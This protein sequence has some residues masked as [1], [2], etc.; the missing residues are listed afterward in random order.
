MTVMNAQSF[1]T[2]RVHIARL[3]IIGIGGREPAMFLA[4]L[5][6]KSKSDRTG[7]CRK[8]IQNPEN[9]RLLEPSA[10]SV[11]S[12]QERRDPNI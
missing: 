5:P 11:A 12:L 8:I 10:K 9:Y 4:I 7:Y 2:V 3:S 1:C 6:D